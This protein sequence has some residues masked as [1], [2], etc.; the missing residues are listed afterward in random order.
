MGPEKGGGKPDKAWREDQ[1]SWIL[2]VSW[3]AGG[4]LPA[5]MP[6]LRNNLGRMP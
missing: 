3:E 1:A 2:M 6:M 4:A 5:A